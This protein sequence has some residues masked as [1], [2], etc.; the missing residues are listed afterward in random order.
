MTTAT[1][2]GARAR[3]VTSAPSMPERL[4]ADPVVPYLLPEGPQTIV[5]VGCGGTGSHLADALASLAIECRRQQCAEPRVVLVDGDRV[6]PRNTIRQRF[7]E[8]EIGR[9]KVHAVAGRLAH[10][11]GVAFE[12]VAEMATSELLERVVGADHGAPVIVVGAVDTRAARREIARYVVGR[13]L[14]YGV[15]GRRRRLWLDCGNGD[16]SG[17]VLVGDTADL[18]ALKRPFVLGGQLCAVLPAP[19]VVEP[20]LIV[21][22]PPRPAE[23][24]VSCA[25]A[26]EAGE[27]DPLI[28][29][30]M[31][32]IAARYLQALIL[33]RRLEHF[34]TVTDLVSLTT[35]STRITRGT[36]AA[37]AASAAHVLK[38]CGP[39]VS[40]RRPR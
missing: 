17:Q 39:L 10:D 22:P 38:A 25:V 4:G 19:F 37:V 7:L 21:D 5:L 8:R 9:Y 32:A 16:A 40:D 3:P 18:K 34:Q 29:R 6:E 31:A 24:V 14:L 23:A 33:Q 35:R 13:D 2:R 15:A 20:T 1:R 11:V 27:Q 12:P 28:N 36:L 30:H 26:V